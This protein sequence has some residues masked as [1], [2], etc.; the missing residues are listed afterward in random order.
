LVF[1]V[2]RKLHAVFGK[3]DALNTGFARTLEFH[4]EH[5]LDLALFQQRQPNFASAGLD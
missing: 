3:L 2:G 4:L 5:G 1:D